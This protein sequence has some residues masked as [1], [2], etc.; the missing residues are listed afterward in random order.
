MFLQKLKI[1]LW[2]NPKSRFGWGENA[3]ENEVHKAMLRQKLSKSQV[4][5]RFRVESMKAMC[6]NN[7]IHSKEEGG[8]GKEQKEQ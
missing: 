3:C 4:K 1:S 8:D 7:H 5:E 6:R 2:G